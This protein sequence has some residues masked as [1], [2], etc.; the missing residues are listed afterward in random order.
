[1][2]A[3]APVLSAAVAV[4]LLLGVPLPA[5]GGPPVPAPLLKKLERDIAGAL[6]HVAGLRRAAEPRAAVP[7]VAGG[8]DI[9]AGADMVDLAPLRSTLARLRGRLAELAVE[10]R[11]RGDPRLE[12]VLHIMR[13]ELGR[14]QEEV[15]GLDAVRDPEARARTV[16]R[17]E[18]G[19]VQLDGATAALWTFDP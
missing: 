5:A 6:T 12:Y 1:V 9:A 15:D 10:I 8:V 3:L 2:R 14:M 13:E 7:A 11:S 4:L 16:A 17:L 18:H 19:L